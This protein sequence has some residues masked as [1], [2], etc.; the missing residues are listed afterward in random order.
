MLPVAGRRAGSVNS[1][2]TENRLSLAPRPGRA[3]GRLR[4]L[5]L[6]SRYLV[7]TGWA[8]RDAD[9]QQQWFTRYSSGEQPPLRVQLAG[10]DSAG[11]MAEL[12]VRVLTSFIKLN[13]AL[14]KFNEALTKPHHGLVGI[15]L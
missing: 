13:Q 8:A 11:L 4:R 6:H 9:F 3:L 2:Q 14:T 15:L 7:V 1:R 5:G 12:H 10:N